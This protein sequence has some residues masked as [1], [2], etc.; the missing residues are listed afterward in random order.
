MSADPLHLIQAT[1]PASSGFRKEKYTLD[2]KTIQSKMQFCIRLDFMQHSHLSVTRRLNGSRQQK[3]M[4]EGRAEKEEEL[5]PMSLVCCCQCLAASLFIWQISA[6]IRLFYN[7]KY[8]LPFLQIKIL[9]LIPK[10]KLFRLQYF[11]FTFLY[12]GRFSA[13][14]LLK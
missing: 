14:R 2:V 12:F 11:H 7:S 9:K 13:L 4:G 8:V 10:S 5:Y 3:Q 6:R 1:K